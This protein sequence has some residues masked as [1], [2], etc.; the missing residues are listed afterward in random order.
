MM[1][2][3]SFFVLWW[4]WRSK[5]AL[6]ET[7]RKKNENYLCFCLSQFNFWAC[8]MWCIFVRIKKINQKLPKDEEKKNEW[9]IDSL[10]MKYC[11]KYGKFSFDKFVST[12]HFV[13]AANDESGITINSYISCTAWCHN[14]YDGDDLTQKTVWLHYSFIPVTQLE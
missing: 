14:L 13:C 10:K 2:T 7:R 9:H 11:V 6:D 1:S 4:M 5:N 3:R 8:Q 12:S